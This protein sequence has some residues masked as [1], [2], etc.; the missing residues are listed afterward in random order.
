M[1]E[2]PSTQNIEGAERE[3]EIAALTALQN[4]L[5]GKGTMGDVD[6]NAIS[7]G[8]K[9]TLI[10][11][12]GR[13]LRPPRPRIEIIDSA[14]PAPVSGVERVVKS[15][16]AA[17]V[18]FTKDRGGLYLPAPD[19][20]QL[21]TFL[22]IAQA[23]DNGPDIQI[24]GTDRIVL[25]DGSTVVGVDSGTLPNGPSA[26]VVFVNDDPTS[27]AAQ[28]RG[29]LTEA[30]FTS[31]VIANHDHEAAPPNSYAQIIAPQFLAGRVAIGVRTHKAAQIKNMR[32]S[33]KKV[34]L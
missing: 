3:A 33:P 16:I 13:L 14:P 2:Q 27:A 28:I 6:I 15:V 25:K 18:G 4:A 7:A 22:S 9:G 12:I 23:M 11:D 31:S 26:V 21:E 34:R 20:A 8:A 5:N 32:G 1:S 30:G 29:M 19:P 10:Q 17:A 24:P